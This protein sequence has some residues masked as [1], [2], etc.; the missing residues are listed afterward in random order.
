MMAWNVLD[1]IDVTE[2]GMQMFP[3]DSAKIV[4]SDADNK[5]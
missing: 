3:N 2:W 4:A 5:K 1:S